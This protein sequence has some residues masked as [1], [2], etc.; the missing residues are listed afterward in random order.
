MYKCC[1]FLI[2]LANFFVFPHVSAMSL[3]EYAQ[4]S[5]EGNLTHKGAKEVLLSH[6]ALEKAAWGEL[7]PKVGFTMGLSQSNVAF[8]PV[9]ASL[10]NDNSTSNLVAIIAQQKLFDRATFV[11]IKGAKLEKNAAKILYDKSTQKTLL[12]VASVYFDVLAAQESI[13]VATLYKKLTETVYQQAKK[14]ESLGLITNTQVY[15]SEAQKEAAVSKTMRAHQ[16]YQHLLSL[17]NQIS[18][19]H[20]KQLAPLNEK[21]SLEQQ[22][23]WSKKYWVKLALNNN[24][25]IKAARLSLRI[26]QTQIQQ[27]AGK[28][29]PT[30][31][32]YASYAKGQNFI[33]EDPAAL[34]LMGLINQGNLNYHGTVVGLEFKMPLFAGGEI[35]HSVK[36]KFHLYQ[37]ELLKFK[38]LSEQLSL[39]VEE[40]YDNLSFYQT[41][42]KQA[43]LEVKAN[44]FEL[45]AQKIE[46]D[47]GKITPLNFLETENRLYAS[48]MKQIIAKTDYIKNLI[49]LQ[50]LVGK[51]NLNTIHKMNRWLIA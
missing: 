38:E 5:L 43:A 50:F 15:S 14:N 37:N 49:E 31:S 12:Q 16:N 24:F 35:N 47:Q 46:L 3:A 13:Q 7:L 10:L 34:V 28:Y 9:I 36:E 21:A 27:A 48:Q 40:H 8:N 32:A 4:K 19:C 45:K 2:F 39:Q 25:D 44:S 18:R 17:L 11:A 1:V 23:H 6:S 22:K 26:V 41:E 20:G 33:A 29:W 42:M 51:L 30:L